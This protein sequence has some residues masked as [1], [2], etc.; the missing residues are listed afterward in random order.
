MILTEL[1]TGKIPEIYK[2]FSNLVDEK[3]WKSRVIQL[4]QELKGNELLTHFIQQENSIAFQLESIRELIVELETSGQ[5]KLNDRTIYPAASFAAQ[6]MGIIKASPTKLAEQF[7]RRI[8]GAFRNPDDMRGL[9]LE[10]SAATHFVNRGL[11]ISWPEMTGDGTFDLLVNGLG[12][13]GLE[14]ECKSISEDKGRKIHKRE[15][16]D[17]YK[18]IQ[19]HL[20][21]IKGQLTIGLS[22]VLTISGRLPTKY[23]EKMELANQVGQHILQQKNATF[24]DGS[25]I[26][27]SKFDAK[28]LKGGMS[29]TIAQNLRS[30]IDTISG[31]VNRQAMLIGNSIGGAIL[32]VV[33]ST[34]DDTFLKAIFD[35]LSDSAKRQFSKCRGG[36]FLTGLQ[37]ISP[38]QLK[39]IATQD[40]DPSA[41]LTGLH[42]GVS[43]FLNSADREHIVGVGFLS[44]AQLVQESAGI[45]S[46]DGTAYYFP[47]RDSSLWSN[48][49]SGLFG[50]AKEQPQ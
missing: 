4:N 39:S 38:E 7:I 24:Q 35:T 46:A 30:I 18:L 9:R 21:N 42:Y 22:V 19:P 40:N 49:Y 13:D 25:S 20:E 36:M 41:P 48:D 32:V 10:L 47:K 6:A 3:H 34:S 11:S 50:W 31:T 28:V 1:E 5:W 45:V 2:E 16:L 23:S 26:R 12:P 29:T 33:E 43:K 44:D 8:H 14:V 27:V 37:G 15:A 17:F